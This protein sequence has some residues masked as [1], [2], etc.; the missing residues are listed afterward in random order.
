MPTPTKTVGNQSLELVIDP[1]LVE[2][3]FSAWIPANYQ[4]HKGKYFQSQ[5]VTQ[6]G[7]GLYLVHWVRYPEGQ[8]EAASLQESW[9]I[10]VTDPAQVGIELATLTPRQQAEFAIAA[11]VK[12]ETGFLLKKRE[13]NLTLV[14][15]LP[16]LGS[17]RKKAPQEDTK[18]EVTTY[19]VTPQIQVV[20]ISGR[21]QGEWVETRTVYVRRHAYPELPVLGR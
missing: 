4:E 3:E 15:T 19:R 8:P 13:W 16:N 5:L 14:P 12:A 7:H 1:N 9:T 10:V 20:T 6:L 2:I 18:I 17:F 21:E 11:A